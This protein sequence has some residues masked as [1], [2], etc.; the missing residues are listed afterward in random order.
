MI[1]KNAK[2]YQ[3]KQNILKKYQNN[4]KNAENKACEKNIVSQK[5]PK[6]SRQIDINLLKRLALVF[7]VV[8]LIFSVFVS[9]GAPY[10]MGEVWQVALAE[11]DAPPTEQEIE[12]ELDGQ[13]ERDLNEI[14]FS[15]LDALASEIGEA[16]EMV[17]GGLSFK[18]TVLSIIRGELVADF[19]GVL[20]SMANSALIGFKK[21]FS[22]LL[23][24][25][26][27]ALLYCLYNN[28]LSHK[29]AGISDVVRIVC[30]GVIALI[31]LTI[32]GAIIS[33]TTKTIATLGR[34][35]NAI[36]PVL[37]TLMTAVGGASTVASFS[38]IIM[39][40]SSMISNIFTHI[41]LPLFTCVLVLSVVN[42]F[43]ANRNFSRLNGFF[44]SLF[45]W[46]IGTVFT[47]FMMILSFK[48][49]TAGARDGISIKATK[50][51]IKNYVPYLGGFVSDGFEMVRVSGILIKNSVG[52]GGILLL[53]ATVIGP[54]ISI[55]LFSLSSRLLSGLVEPLGDSKV[56]EILDSVANAFKM[57]S[58]ILIGVA[59]MFLFSLVMIII[60]VNVI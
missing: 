52:F 28:L 36:F 35:M 1:T 21:S 22:T 39:F 4:V 56:A 31:I 10:K 47:L 2:L 46:I 23:L 30:V 57:L 33:K 41:L 53:V 42:C 12:K 20:K 40:L 8:S 17:F 13:V 26:V 14:D 29:Q 18:E 34:Q 50:Y 59:L 24:V 3:N 25:L 5:P 15:E 54:I 37:L 45:K 19:G 43:S 44:K 58:A 32:A 49:A 16:G 55:A 48:G 51:A 11:V 9:M 60:T 7:L 6:R 27:V 38:P